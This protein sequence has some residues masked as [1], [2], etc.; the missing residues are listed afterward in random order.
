VCEFSALEKLDL[1]G[2][3][4]K[5]EPQMIENEDDRYTEN[6]NDEIRSQ[7]EETF[8][9][10][11][12]DENDGV[13]GNE[14][15]FDDNRSYVTDDNISQFMEPVNEHPMIMQKYNKR[16][17][18]KRNISNIVVG[19]NSDMEFD[20]IEDKGFGVVKINRPYGMQSKTQSVYSGD[21]NESRV[22]E[23]NPMTADGF[24]D[25]KFYSHPLW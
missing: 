5:V 9:Q 2:E 22:S 4:D 10:S 11:E 24:F 6:N 21:D 16:Q 23:T 3:S 15:N 13:V 17:T 8:T 19:T 18:G 14:I 7:N 1:N 12:V 25:L 20:Q